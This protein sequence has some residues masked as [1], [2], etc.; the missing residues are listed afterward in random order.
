M[1]RFA[2]VAL[3]LSCAAL[4]SFAEIK[5]EEIEYT[6]DGVVMRGFL[7]YDDAV[8]EKRPGVLVVHEWWGLNDYARKRARMLAQMGYTALA[9]D[10]YGDGKMA[11]H[12]E[13]ASKFSGE[14]FKNMPVAK[15]RFTAALDLLK[16]Q[17]TVDPERV[18]AIGY[19]FGGGIVLHMARMGVDLNGVASFH[20]SLATQTPAEEGDIKANILVCNGA[21]DPFVTQEDIAKFKNE[22]EQAKAD[23]TFKSYSG[24][25]HSFTNPAATEAGKKFNLPLAYN[26]K[27]D[28]A[29]WNDL[30]AFFK[31]VF[32]TK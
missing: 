2:M 32:A 22:M 11:T 28:K 4:S 17:E 12:P 26:A 19:C 20:G 25:K 30:K 16:E 24:A 8:K 15:A 6:S 29:S 3:L 21:A 7:V 9:I 10:M 1:T 13:D 18:A 27:A 14:L 31:K 5:G 23:L